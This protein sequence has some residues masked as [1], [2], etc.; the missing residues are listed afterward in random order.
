MPPRN[1]TAHLADRVE[2]V[3]AIWAFR[4][5]LADIKVQVSAK[6]GGGENLAAERAGVV[7]I[8]GR[9]FTSV[10]TIGVGTVR[11]GVGGVRGVPCL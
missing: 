6:G 11:V 4:V 2:I 3:D 7:V 9:R 5:L 10:W 8:Y 1:A